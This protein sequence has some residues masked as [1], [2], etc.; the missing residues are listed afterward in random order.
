MRKHVLVTGGAGFI[1]SHLVDALILRGFEV[2]ILDI[3]AKAN[4]D[5]VNPVAK[6][7]Q[8]DLTK[9]E[10]IEMV[11]LLNPDIIFHLAANASVAKSVAD[12]VMDYDINYA[13]TVRLL[14]VAA[15]IGVERFIFS[16]TG[17][18]LSSEYTTIPTS[19]IAASKPLSPYAMHKLASEQMGEF[20]RLNRGV[21]FVALRFANVYGPRQMA[22]CGE[23]NVTAT[24]AAR[25]VANQETMI[26]GAGR[27]T[28]DY[29]YVS[30]VIRA[31]VLLLDA[32]T[33]NGPYNVGS[34]IELDVLTIHRVMSKY[35]GYTQK[36]LIQPPQ[37]GEPMRSCLDI[38]KIY[39]QLGWIPQVSFAQGIARTID[40]HQTRVSQ[41]AEAVAHNAQ[42]A[43]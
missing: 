3:A 11:K 12:P 42:L 8:A 15:M 37:A 33:A 17:G 20:Y 30:D 43:N 28:R 14:E 22:T 18:A 40:W 7:L 35:S 34:G 39:D 27:Q 5:H 2:T 19:E 21:P 32:D 13:A 36:P 24:F 31:C 23:A 6:Y 4:R 16:S 26:N 41:L 10:T 25:M 38:A 1:G 29:V 9:R